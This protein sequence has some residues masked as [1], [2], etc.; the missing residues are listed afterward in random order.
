MQRIADFYASEVMQRYDNFAAW[1]M[2][3]SQELADL[4][5]GASDDIVA[6]HKDRNALITDLLSSLVIESSGWLMFNESAHPG[7][8]V[9][10]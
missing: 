2:A 7:G 6:M 10:W 1:P 4:M 8:P 9:L 5:I 3:N